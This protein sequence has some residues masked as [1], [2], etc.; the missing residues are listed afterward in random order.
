MPNT[1]DPSKVIVTVAGIPI[2]GFAEDGLISA[3]RDDQTWTKHVG[4][5]GDVGRAKT[6]NKAGLVKVSLLQTSTSNDILSLIHTVDETTGAGIVPL[7]ITDLSG[8]TTMVSAQAWIRKLPVVELKKGIGTR[9]WEFDCDVLD[10]HVAGNA[11]ASMYT[12]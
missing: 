10:I 11:A 5:T 2:S 12:P 4:C 6:C 7:V 3:E 1:Y 8:G 9:E